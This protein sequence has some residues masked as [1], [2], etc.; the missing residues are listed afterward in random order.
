MAGV[1][2]V[3]GI[4]GMAVASMASIMKYGVHLYM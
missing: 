1:T 4:S 2:L 3:A